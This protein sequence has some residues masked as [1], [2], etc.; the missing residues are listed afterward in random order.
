MASRP[1]AYPYIYEP[2][3]VRWVRL[4]KTADPM[5]HKAPKGWAAKPIEMDWHPTE[6]TKFQEPFWFV[7]ETYVGEMEDVT[8]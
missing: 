1:Y 2:G 5:K 3:A 8:C 6:F 4:P 7:R